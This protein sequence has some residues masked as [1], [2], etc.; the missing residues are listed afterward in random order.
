MRRKILS[1]VIAVM[2]IVGGSGILSLA[3]IQVVKAVSDSKTQTIV[4]SVTSTI[5]LTLATSTVNLGTLA[6]GTPLSATTSLSVTTNDGNGWNLQVMRD[7]ATTTLN[8]NGTSTP[9]TTFPDATAWAYATPNATT[10]ANVGANLSFRIFQTG[11]DAALYNASWWGADDTAPNAL[12]AGFPATNQQLAT[13]ASYV[14]SAQA[15]AYGFRADAP[16]TQPGGTYSGTVTFT[17]ITN[18]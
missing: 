9:D 13:I 10:S 18:P 6:P 8:L 5:T 1:A 4:L 12:F 7:D 15:V 2:M 14:G 17:A 3:R 16:G 11:T